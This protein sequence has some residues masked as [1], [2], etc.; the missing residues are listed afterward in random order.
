MKLVIVGDALGDQDYARGLKAMASRD[1]VFA[2]ARNA[3]DVRTL[4]KQ[5]AL[6]LHPSCL[7]GFAMVVLEALAADAPLLVSDIA[8]HLEVGM[9]EANYYPVGNVVSLAGVL[10]GGSYANLRC[11][12]R[13]AILEENNWDAVARRHREILVRPVSAR[14]EAPAAASS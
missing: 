12:K 9:D 5:A 6:F 7:E 3:A 4:Y 14:R 10:A 1:V 8:P 13:A 11:S 2:G